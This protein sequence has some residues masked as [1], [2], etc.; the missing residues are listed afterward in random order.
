MFSDVVRIGSI[1]IFH[2]SKLWKPKFFIRV[3]ILWGR[4]GNWKLITYQSKGLE[5][6][7]Y[8]HSHRPIDQTLSSHFL[9][10]STGLGNARGVRAARNEWRVRQETGSWLQ[11]RV[12]R[13]VGGKMMDRVTPEI[14]H[15]KSNAGTAYWTRW[16][17]DHSDKGW[18]HFPH[19]SL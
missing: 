15:T 2:L 16:K 6:A 1:I 14:D 5:L 3:M 9:G 19:H 17:M 7:G 18:N 4:R 13:G 11:V 8:R 10:F 12:Y